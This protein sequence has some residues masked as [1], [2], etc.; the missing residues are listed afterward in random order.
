[1]KI[2]CSTSKVPVNAHKV[3]R[4]IKNFGNVICSEDKN[5]KWQMFNYR[6]FIGVIL[7]EL[8]I[9]WK[10]GDYKIEELPIM[11]KLIELIKDKI[12]PVI[13]PNDVFECYINKEEYIHHLR[14]IAR[15]KQINQWNVLRDILKKEFSVRKWDH[16]PK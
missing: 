9:K 4:Y 3:R 2:F 1:M 6:G 5:G 10:D 8:L 7:N 16:I 11:D 12:T 13:N 15:R 14:I